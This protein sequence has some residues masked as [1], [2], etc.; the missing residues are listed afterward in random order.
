MALD[1]LQEAKTIN[2]IQCY[3]ENQNT[4]ALEKVGEPIGV[5]VDVKPL[6]LKAREED[7]INENN[8]KSLQKEL[9]NLRERI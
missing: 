5:V 7:K 6:N 9:Y 1:I 2:L 4:T 8:K 3:E